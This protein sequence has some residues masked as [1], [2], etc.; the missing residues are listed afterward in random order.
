M[1][2]GGSAAITARAARWRE[3]L[4]Q[5][6][7]LRRARAD[8]RPTGPEARAHA[9]RAATF[10]RMAERHLAERDPWVAGDAAGAERVA[11]SLYRD[12]AREALD[13]LGPLDEAQYAALA[14]GVGPAAAAREALRERPEETTE[15]TRRDLA[16]ARSFVAALL[17]EAAR[18]GGDVDPLLARRFTRAGGLIVALGLAALA[19]KAAWYAAHPD[20]APDARWT[21]SSAAAGYEATG[22]GFA[23]PDFKVPVFFHTAEERSPSITFDLERLVDVR[24]VLVVNRGDC[25][26][27][28]AVP[29]AVEVSENSVTWIEVGRRTE[30]FRRWEARFAPAAARWVRLRSLRATHLHLESVAIR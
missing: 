27:D 17:D 28:R 20:R 25:C 26:D 15:E 11:L 22:R 24:S 19:P 2:T 3:W 8:A 1:K 13:A 14:G 21:A 10:A 9:A 18:R 5:G 6:E 30:P 4:W 12:A 29:L 23:P 16:A 7:A